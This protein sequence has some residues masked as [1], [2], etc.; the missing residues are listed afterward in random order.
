[1]GA[2]CGPSELGGSRVAVVP[3]RKMTYKL[4]DNVILP[5]LGAVP[6]RVA[7]VVNRVHSEGSQSVL[8]RL[9][10]LSTK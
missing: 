6:E 1:M 10:T 7:E 5:R 2:K 3:K 9:P 4:C 8:L